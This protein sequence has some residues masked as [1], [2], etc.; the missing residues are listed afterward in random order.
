MTLEGLINLAVTL[1]DRVKLDDAAYRLR[2]WVQRPTRR[3]HRARACSRSTVEAL[4]V[5]RNKAYLLGVVTSR[6]RDEAATITVQRSA[7]THRCGRRCR[8]YRPHE[9][10]PMPIRLAA[11]QLGVSPEQCIMVGD[12]AVDIRAGKAAGA[13]AVGVRSGFGEDR[14][15]AEADLVL[16]TSAQLVTWL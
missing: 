8:G 14:D 9:A 13:L 5:L 11:Q 3:K 4:R 1:L 6:D 10:H 15:F 12:T 7:T 16:D 2:R